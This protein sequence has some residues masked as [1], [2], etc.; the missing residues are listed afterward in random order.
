GVGGGVGLLDGNAFGS[1]PRTCRG[2]TPCIVLRGFSSSG[3][4][5]GS[6]LFRDA[7]RQLREIRYPAHL[8]RASS[9]ASRPCLPNLTKSPLQSQGAG[10]CEGRRTAHQIVVDT[11]L[12]VILG[13]VP[14]IQSR[15]SPG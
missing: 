14:R 3:G 5:K 6:D 10:A 2:Q 1:E 12:S 15:P 13:L 9:P 11:E 4:S 7:I 8:R